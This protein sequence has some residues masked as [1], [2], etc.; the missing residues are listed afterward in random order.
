M[1]SIHK[2]RFFFTDVDGVLTDG[3]LY[4]GPDGETFKVFNVQDGLGLTLLKKAGFT[5]GAISGRSNAAL[6]RRL[7]DLQFEHVFLGIDDKLATYNALKKQLQFSDE[8]VIYIGDDVNDLELLK[9]VGFPLTVR[10]AHPDVIPHAIWQSQKKGGAGA[11]REACD[12]ILNL[13]RHLP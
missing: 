2:A 12:W 5:L 10:N 6:Q 1:K 4:Y 3:R 9:R 8:E 13:K 11:V 7:A